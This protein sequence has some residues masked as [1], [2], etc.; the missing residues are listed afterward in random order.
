MSGN[1]ENNQCTD[2]WLKLSREA[3]VGGGT[4]CWFNLRCLSLNVETVIQGGSVEW[5]NSHPNHWKFVRLELLMEV[6]LPWHS[7]SS[8]HSKHPPKL[9]VFSDALVCR[10]L[11]LG[12]YIPDGKVWGM[13]SGHI[14][15]PPRLKLAS[16]RCVY[17]FSNFVFKQFELAS[18][19]KVTYSSLLP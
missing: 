7:P 3:N 10:A 2:G 12:S 15:T 4:N 11:A 14:L 19:W 13:R 1:T 17:R 16:F 6:E 5:V 8:T 18:I 9:S